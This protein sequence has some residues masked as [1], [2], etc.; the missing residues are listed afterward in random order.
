[1]IYLL[2][3][4]K[5]MITQ[6]CTIA[7]DAEL[8]YIE[9]DKFKT[10]YISFSFITNLKEENL[11]N[12][13]CIPK[14]LLEGCQKYRSKKEL[15]KRL[16]YLYSGEIRGSSSSY[17]EFYK[18]SL[19][20]DFL[21]E[22]Y[23][24]DFHINDESIDL[25][26]DIIFRPLLR[27]GCFLK[28]YTNEIKADTIDAIRAEINNKTTYAVSTCKKNMYKGEVFGIGSKG[29]I[30]NVE[31]ITG[32]TLYKA[33]KYALEHFRVEIY[34][35][36]NY[37]FESVK[38]KFGSCFKNIK[39]VKSQTKKIEPIYKKDT[40]AKEIVESQ[41]ITQGKLVMGF[42]TGTTIESVDYE[43]MC[44]FNEILGGSPTSKLFMNV[45]EKQ[46]LCYFCSSVVSDRAGGL[47]IISGIDFANKEKVQKAIL[48]ELENMRSGK[49]T[50][51]EIE[52][53]KKSIM[54]TYKQ[55]SDGPSAM[56][57]WVFSRT[58]SGRELDP[59]IEMEKVES[60][61]KED[62][63]SFSKKIK[64]DT[65]FFLKGDDCNE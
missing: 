51:T 34:L 17:G 7:K 28:K 48:K 18:I 62:I 38:N 37:D 24:G 21:N 57:F 26:C 41:H 44:V 58:I 13:G 45:R 43:A 30:E 52:N 19:S 14:I 9:S 35:V 16:K 32:K 53:A 59:K 23:T 25:L 12:Y 11:E 31:K 2:E 8:I 6:K 10:N 49:I 60:I 29:K 20:A 47:F 27:S 63:V 42:R 22:K 46:S 15:S 3:V 33:Y 54:T 55:I 36:G 40:K 1:M 5:E 64:L 56:Q 61:K 65:I 50:K 4:S 39:R